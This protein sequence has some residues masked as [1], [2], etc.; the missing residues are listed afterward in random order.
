[1][2]FL[3]GEN[4]SH[5]IATALQAI[6]KPVKHVH[7]I[8]QPGTSDEVIFE[9]LK[10]LGWILVS[11]DKNISRKKHQKQ[12]MLQAGIGA[13]I[14]TGRANKSNDDMLVMMVRSF[15]EFVELTARSG[16]PFIYGVP[17]KGRIRPIA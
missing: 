6:G 8:L 2:T 7:E 4:I 3:L 12:A 14:F 10:D 16:R 17:D 13:F 15:P 1:M 5:R 11:Q 9:K